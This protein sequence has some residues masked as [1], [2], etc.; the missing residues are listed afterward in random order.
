MQG[1]S[2]PNNLTFP[3]GSVQVLP[4]SNEIIAHNTERQDHI[5]G[6]NKAS[7]FAGYFCAR[8]DQDIAEW[9]IASNGNGSLFPGR[10][11]AS[12]EQLSAY[13]RFKEGVK[14]VNMRVGVSFISAEQ[15]R[16]S[17]EKE[18]PDGQTLEETARQTRQAWAE[19]LDRVRIEGSGITNDE[20]TVFYTGL[21]HSLQ[22]R[23]PL[24]FPQMSQN[25]ETYASSIH[26]NRARMDS[27]IQDTMTPCMKASRI[28]AIPSG[29]S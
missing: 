15:A 22:V 27:T 3:L 13:V 21:F 25:D 26:T 10:S 20:K 17:L 2:D 16:K 8:F 28:L 9:G 23:I 24:I 19:K 7:G 14:I 4:Q 29:Y 18:I 1:S 11:S 12:G 6:P 5:I